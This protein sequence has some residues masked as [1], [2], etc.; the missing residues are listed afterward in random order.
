MKKA[1]QKKAKAVKS[2]KQPAQ[3]TTIPAVQFVAVI[4]AKLALEIDAAVSVNGTARMILEIKSPVPAVGRVWRALFTK[5]FNGV[6]AHGD[7]KRIAK[8]A[9]ELVIDIIADAA[10]VKNLK[11]YAGIIARF[12]E[13][14]DCD[15]FEQLG[16]GI[17]RERKGKVFSQDEWFLLLNWD[18]WL[19]RWH[20]E[21]AEKNIPPLRFW[22]DEAIFG[23]LQS[24][25][26]KRDSDSKLDV[27]TTRTRLALPKE[28]A[29][30]QVTG[31]VEVNRG[32]YSVVRPD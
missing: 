18:E 5:H 10:A 30:P 6:N 4:V 7:Y 27:K 31:Y 25:S 13:V 23:L 14:N 12:A 2:A 21:L 29:P 20:T 19:E 17:T 8:V 26:K 1:K 15:F 32:V 11:P 24:L 9:R 3:I 22:T 16:R 28:K